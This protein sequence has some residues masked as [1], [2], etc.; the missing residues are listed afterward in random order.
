[1]E[2]SDGNPVGWLC[3]RNVGAMQVS[4]KALELLDLPT[5]WKDLEFPM[6]P[7]V[8]EALGF[9]AHP[10]IVSRLTRIRD[11]DRGGVN[12]AIG[13][14]KKVLAHDEHD[15]P[16][17]CTV[18]LSSGIVVLVHPIWHAKKDAALHLWL[19]HDYPP[20]PGCDSASR[21]HLV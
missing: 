6:Y 14:T 21:L 5:G 13:D 11:K 15:S 18:Q 3:V 17:I 4:Q 16:C 7:N 8:G 9:Y 20:S 2:R 1:M 10:G 19:C 12:G